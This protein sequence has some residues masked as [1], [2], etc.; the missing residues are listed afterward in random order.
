LTPV[1]PP[2]ELPT[3]MNFG[4]NY[5]YFTGNTVFFLGGRLQNTRSRPINIATGLMFI[6]PGALFFVFSASW[7]WHNISPSIPIAF[8]YVYYLALS[9]FMHASLSDPG[10]SRIVCIISL[11]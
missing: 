7:L 4:S 8:A 3:S 6:I 1:D 5:E 10:V 11:C 9:S 2:K